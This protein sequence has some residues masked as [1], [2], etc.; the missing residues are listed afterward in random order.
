[1]ELNPGWGEEKL[2]EDCDTISRKFLFVELLG[3]SVD[4]SLAGSRSRWPVRGV[5]STVGNVPV[6][7]IPVLKQNPPSLA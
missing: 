4:W 6:G 5:T 2:L 7:K 1:M 3:Q